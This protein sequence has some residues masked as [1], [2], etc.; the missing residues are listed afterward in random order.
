MKIVV[1][2]HACSLPVNQGFYAEVERLTG[3]SLSFVIP[4][5]WRNEYQRHIKPVRLEGL[6]GDIHYV[7]VWNSGS[8]PLHV[9]KSLLIRH[10]QREDPDAIY[11][12]HEPYGL[13]TMQVYLA[14]RF[15]GQ[16]PIGFYAAQ[17]IMKRYP[18]PIRILEDYVLSHSQFCF[19][20]TDGA[21]SVLRAKGYRG[22]T[23]VLPLPVNSAV[24]CP[25]PAEAQRL[26]SRLHFDAHT[27]VIGYLGRLVE[28]KGLLNL[29]RALSLIPDRSWKCVIVGA[30]PLEA[31]LRKVV[32]HAALSD[33][34]E[35]IGYVPHEEA[36][37]WLAAF[38]V[39]V[40]PSETGTNW[41]EQ[42]GRVLIEA[43]ACGTPVIGTTCGEIPAVIRSTGGGLIV[44]EADPQALADALT[45]LIV[46]PEKLHLLSEQGLKTVGEEYGQVHL[47]S[48]FAQTIEAAV[49][50]G[51]EA[52]T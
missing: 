18:L 16:C 44:P 1:V 35:L 7:P 30:G 38:D 50:S 46:E 31:K 42:F 33:F 12:H 9:Y 5:A 13:A 22:A 39:L 19:P 2:S 14:N 25:Q 36:P 43:N 23:Q 4:A 11:V 48:K 47:A 29:I 49:T 37:G 32:L 20:V 28:E 41:K 6:R 40:L 17:N 51:R 52:Q 10:L 3:W 27:F 8:V 34:V 45:Q 15:A 26:R 24:Y 21:L